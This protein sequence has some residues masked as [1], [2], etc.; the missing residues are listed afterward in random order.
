ME[1]PDGGKSKNQDMEVGEKGQDKQA[2][3]GEGGKG[4]L[5]IMSRKYP[6]PL[7]SG[8]LSLNIGSQ[9]RI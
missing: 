9:A 6:Y 5:G 2:R 4:K 8:N 1:A 3:E 7:T